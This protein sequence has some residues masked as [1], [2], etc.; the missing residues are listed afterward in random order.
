M[1]KVQVAIRVRPFNRRE[2]EA[3]NDVSCVTMQDT[4][5]ILDTAYSKTGKPQ[6]RYSLPLPCLLIILSCLPFALFGKRACV[7][8][9]LLLAWANLLRSCRCG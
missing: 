6:V 4:Q 2:I 3:K 7:C 5:T 1:S 9:P 8:V